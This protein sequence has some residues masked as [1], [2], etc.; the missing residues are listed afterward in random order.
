MDKQ[1]AQ[2][3]LDCMDYSFCFDATNGHGNHSLNRPST[4][5][6]YDY[7]EY[8][9]RSKAHKDDEDDDAF[10]DRDGSKPQAAT[11]SLNTDEYR[12]ISD[13]TTEIDRVK[14]KLSTLWNNVKYG[15]KYCFN[16]DRISP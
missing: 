16:C 10:Y 11:A 2:S 1:H 9:S 5:N 4:F 3:S 8:N 12:Y 15:K 14:N 13:N 7:V 6:E